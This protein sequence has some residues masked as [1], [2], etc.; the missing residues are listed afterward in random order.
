VVVE[1]TIDVDDPL[2][3]PNIDLYG[4]LRFELAGLSEQGEVLSYGRS[5]EIAVI[6]DLERSV[7][8]TFLPVNKVLTLGAEFLEP[9]S[10]H[11]TAKGPDGRV[12]LLGGINTARTN[13]LSSI[14]Y[15]EPETG[16][17]IPL[18]NFL[19]F[20][21]TLP[22][23][24]WTDDE[25][26]MVH[27]G[28]TV[29]N[30]SA[31]VPA[32]SINRIDAATDGVSVL[33][34]SGIGRRDH[35]FSAFDGQQS[36]AVGGTE[37]AS[38]SAELLVPSTSHPSGWMWQS[39]AVTNFQTYNIRT[40]ATTSSGRIFFQGTGDQS[41]GVYTPD[42][43]GTSVS[44]FQTIDFQQSSLEYL[45][46]PYGQMIV[47]LDEGRVWMAGG[48]QNLDGDGN[49]NNDP[50]A[51]VS[52]EFNLDTLVFSQ[53]ADPNLSERSWGHWDPWIEPNTYAVGCGGVDG[54]VEVNPNTLVEVFSLETQEVLL[55]VPL[56]RNR[57]GC[58]MD[59]LDDGSILISGGHA[60]G[61]EVTDGG[62]ILVPYLD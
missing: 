42:P 29:I 47:P 46:Y 39:L 11:S 53:G 16:R 27:G 35:C 9:R 25:Q 7:A 45:V 15:Y 3:I 21:T 32:S 51:G 40:C 4:V 36:L 37:G 38:Q 57:P 61:D 59:V 28:G 62:A 50:P 26:L 31:A 43:N 6:P 41:T 20:A 48:R 52:R 24:T 34:S 58:N 30:G 22:S 14:E 2:E 5:S 49:R 55:A 60:E 44:D 18:A 1:E 56:D 23:V 10:F 33:P 12:F 54:N 17:S 19:S 13:S 8:L